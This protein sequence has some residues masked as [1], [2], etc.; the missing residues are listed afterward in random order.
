MRNESG[1][2][3]V[4]LVGHQA[5]GSR[6]T[7]SRVMSHDLLQHHWMAVDSQGHLGGQ[8]RV[9]C[10]SSLPSPT[11]ASESSKP[12]RDRLGTVF[13]RVN[14]P[15]LTILIDLDVCLNFV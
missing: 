1:I 14:V 3:S 5:Q 15:A 8:V 11:F 6:G 12:I 10:S 4:K 2:R 7:D 9:T 13:V